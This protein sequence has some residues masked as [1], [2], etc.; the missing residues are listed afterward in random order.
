MKWE[1]LLNCVACYHC[2]GK[3][4]TVHCLTSI[5][6]QSLPIVHLLLFLVTQ[7]IVYSLFVEITF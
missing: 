5:I 2:Y 7:Y 6:S 4:I 1:S 3:I